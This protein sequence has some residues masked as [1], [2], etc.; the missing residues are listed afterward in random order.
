MTK[1]FVIIAIVITVAA[2][3]GNSAYNIGQ[4]LLN[5]ATQELQ[6]TKPAP[7]LTQPYKGGLLHYVD[8][9]EGK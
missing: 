9:K 7:E 5:I 3:I 4:N 1:Y 8:G 2:C 6:V